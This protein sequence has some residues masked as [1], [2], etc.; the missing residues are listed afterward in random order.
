MPQGLTSN[1]V[2]QSFNLAKGRASS[3]ETSDKGSRTVFRVTEITPAAAPSK[4]QLDKLAGDIQG[5]LANQALTEYTEALKQRL[6]ATIN[7]AEFKRI[8]GISEQ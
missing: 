4:E 7:D 2:L 1:A 5:D 3:V 6:G 8:S